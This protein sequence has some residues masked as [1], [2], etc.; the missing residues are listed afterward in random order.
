MS[1]TA[2][3]RI[4]L[5]AALFTIMSNLYSGAL[6]KRVGNQLLL[7]LLPPLVMALMWPMFMLKVT[8]VSYVC[9][10]VVGAV[11]GVLPT[12]VFAAAPR[13]AVSKGTMG[14]AMAIVIVGENAGILVGPE[15]FGVMR[16]MTG[17]FV[18]PFWMLFAVGLIGVLFSLSIWRSGVFQLAPSHE[19]A[20]DAN[21]SNQLPL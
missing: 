7:F 9:A 12:I 5:V 6:L 11:G 10:A 17:H 13:L 1:L 21:V 15:L 8:V 4:P 3:A 18:L 2:A 16:G 19:E 20:L 14:I